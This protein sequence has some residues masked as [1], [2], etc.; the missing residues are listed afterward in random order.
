MESIEQSIEQ[1]PLGTAL[2]P[3][4]RLR[5]GTSLD[6]PE[7]RPPESS[8]HYP[9]AP[10]MTIHGLPAGGPRTLLR[11]RRRAGGRYNRGDP[12]PEHGR[13]ETP[14]FCTRTDASHIRSLSRIRLRIADSRSKEALLMRA[15]ERQRGT[16]PGGKVHGRIV[17]EE[18]KGRIGN[19]RELAQTRGIAR[20]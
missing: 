3:V 4:R 17:R 8:R 9:V 20:T 11:T 1:G 7:P 14:T 2:G 19:R 15:H 13:R 6:V 10:H 16:G 18:A 5:P 12:G